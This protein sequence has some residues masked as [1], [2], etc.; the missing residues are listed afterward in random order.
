MAYCWYTCPP[1][2]NVPH[3]RNVGGGYSNL[4]VTDFSVTDWL[5]YVNA[6]YEQRAG[7]HTP[8]KQVYTGNAYSQSIMFWVLRDTNF[9]H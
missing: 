6:E 3:A 5:F 4:E 2:Y 7:N 9:I 1:K 8:A